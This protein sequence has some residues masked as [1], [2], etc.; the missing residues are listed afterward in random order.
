MSTRRL[1]VVPDLDQLKHQARDLLRLVHAGDEAAIAELREFHHDPID[2]A[3]AKLADAQLVLARIYEAPSWTRL[4]Q[5]V[6]LVNAIWADDIDTVRDLV[7]RNPN[8][9]HEEALIRKDS[10]WGPP[11]SYAANV[12]RDR[13]IR[14][15]H[16][17][18]ATDPRRRWRAVL[19]A[20]SERRR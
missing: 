8:L 12:G 5:A 4:V 1:P 2:P 20:R 13:I 14:M 17:R 10:N 3:S 18:A 9:I 7:T 16:Q 6:Q 11:M 19:R 15:R